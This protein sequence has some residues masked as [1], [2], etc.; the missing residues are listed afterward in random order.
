MVVEEC[1]LL[2]TIHYSVGKEDRDRMTLELPQVLAMILL[3][4]VMGHLTFEADHVS[5]EEVAEVT[6]SA[7]SEVATSYKSSLRDRMGM[8][9]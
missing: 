9:G 5:Q 4:R 3:D 7:A 1:T 8:G 2:S 6:H